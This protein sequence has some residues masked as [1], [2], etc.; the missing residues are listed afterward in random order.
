M[1]RPAENHSRVT[2]AR[3][4]TVSV[5]TTIP[6]HVARKLKLEA[7]DTLEWDLDKEGA[8]WFARIAKA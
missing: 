6:A 3:P 4:E 2:R 1:G 7:G 8:V 5:R